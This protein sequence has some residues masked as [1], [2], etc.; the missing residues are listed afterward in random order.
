MPEPTDAAGFLA[1]L[2]ELGL[3][4]ATDPGAGAHG[5]DDDCEVCRMLRA[6]YGEPEKIVLPDGSV[7]ETHAM[8]GGR[9]NVTVPLSRGRR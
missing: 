2:R 5:D 1:K 8:P 4:T 6:Q 9:M 7:V 3:L